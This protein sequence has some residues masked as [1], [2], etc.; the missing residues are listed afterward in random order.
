MRAMS[1]LSARLR[2]FIKHDES[3][4][5]LEPMELVY[6]DVPEEFSGTVIQKLSQQKG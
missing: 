4:K 6:I 1:S 2:Y 5:K 3:G